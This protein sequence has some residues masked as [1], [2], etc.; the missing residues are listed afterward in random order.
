ML[1]T[2]RSIFF[3]ACSFVLGPERF[4]V[5]WRTVTPEGRRALGPS[6]SEPDGFRCAAL[7]LRP[8]PDEPFTY[9]LGPTGAVAGSRFFYVSDDLARACRH[10]ARLSAEASPAAAK[11]Y[12]WSCRSRRLSDVPH[13]IAARRGRLVRTLRFVTVPPVASPRFRKAVHAARGPRSWSRAS[14]P[15]AEIVTALL[16]AGLVLVACLDEI[17]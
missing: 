15:R 3:R 10:H 9:S 11:L 17:F 14:V 2:L 1:R 4:A 16:L 5:E 7:E 6:W 13:K 12:L 8:D